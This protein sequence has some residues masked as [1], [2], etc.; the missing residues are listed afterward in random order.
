MKKNILLL[1]FLV[2]L[3]TGC[4]QN[5]PVTSE[6][7]ISAAAS[8]QNALQEIKVLYEE[9]NPDIKLLFNF[10]ST[11]TLQKQIE[12]GAPVDLFF[13]ASQDRYESLVEQD[14]VISGVTLLENQL[15]LIANKKTRIT[16]IEDLVNKEVSRI[17]IGIPETVPAGKYAK[18]SLQNLNLWEQI[19]DKVIMAK[20]VRQVLTYVES[21]NVEVGIVYKTDALIS[22]NID[23]I[24][25]IDSV[26]HDSIKYSIGI[27][28]G[29]LKQ[30][31]AKQFITFLQQENS[32]NIL[33][34]YGFQP[35]K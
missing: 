29:T 19:Q 21:N 6:I 35:I 8:L 16:G 33:H 27:I 34:K 28:K 1:I 20:D 22:N 5:K 30:K 17:A 18:Q 13:S 11:G 7:M 15:V 4:N 10:S 12:Q 31:E 25:V 2:F 32:Q 3:M 24:Q 14:I 23:V 9:E 26:N